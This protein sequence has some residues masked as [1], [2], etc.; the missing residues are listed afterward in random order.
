MADAIAPL[1]QWVRDYRA[2]HGGSN[3]SK[4]DIPADLGASDHVPLHL[5][6]LVLYTAPAWQ[7]FQQQHRTPATTPQRP[8]RPTPPSSPESA[9]S[10]TPAKTWGRTGCIAA[11]PEGAPPPCNLDQSPL[12]DDPIASNPF[13][14]RIARQPL[15]SVQPFTQP[16]PAKVAQQPKQEQKRSLPPACPPSAAPRLARSSSLLQPTVCSYRCVWPADLV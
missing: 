14:R 1:L 5:N 4:E 15:R 13:S 16:S 9:I 10:A 2:C 6:H 7:M 8:C 11:T 12:H 3:P